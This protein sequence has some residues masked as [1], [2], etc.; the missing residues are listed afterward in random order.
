MRMKD[1]SGRCIGEAW[2]GEMDGVIGWFDDE[3]DG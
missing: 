2:W 3:S 1:V